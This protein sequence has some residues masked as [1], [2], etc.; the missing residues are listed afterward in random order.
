MLLMHQ[1]N[2]SV[3]EPCSLIWC[4]QLRVKWKSLCLGFRWEIR[5]VWLVTEEADQVTALI[6]AF[7]PSSTDKLQEALTKPYMCKHTFDIFGG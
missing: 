2:V 7:N 3:G 6:T 5:Q 1:S 4:K